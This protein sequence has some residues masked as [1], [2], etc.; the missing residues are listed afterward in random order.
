[1]TAAR[2]QWPVQGALLGFCAVLG[3][4]AGINPP[5]AV[6]AALAAVFALLVASDLTVGLCVFTVVAFAERIP[7]V[8]ASDLTFVKA[9]GALLAVSWLGAVATKRAGER[10]LFTAHPVMTAMSGLLLAWLIL[11]VS[12]AED[13][14]LARADVLR[15]ALCLSLLPIVYAAVRRKE[16]VAA[17]LGVYVGGAVVSALYAIATR[18]TEETGRISGIVGTANE[19]ASLLVTALLLSVGLLFALRGAPVLR[20]LCLGAAVICL[21]GL[22]LTLSRAGLVALGAALVAAVFVGGRRHVGVALLALAIGI[23]VVGYFSFGASEQARER[24]TTV[25]GGTGR[26]DLWTVALRMVD[27]DPVR[28]VGVGN[29]RTASVHFLLRPGAILRDEYIVDK[30]QVAHNVYLHVLSETGIPGLAL[31]LG[32]VGS[33]LLAAWRAVGEFMRQ[34]DRFL[35]ICSRALVLALIALLVADLFAS[36]QLNKGLWLLLGLG[37]AL[38][39]IA[40][41]ERAA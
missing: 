19:L 39:G 30:P 6:G 37:P 17:V 7:A 23:T 38:L 34:G 27:E 41:S 25:G 36:D 9:L 22:F 21:A 16:H 10:Q 11:S 8:G 33:A 31:F 3:L 12:W 18:G 15:Y 32:I 4:L 29:F 26:T 13:P 24:V 20:A 40:R 1:V 2:A 14:A 35:E 28:G 5:V